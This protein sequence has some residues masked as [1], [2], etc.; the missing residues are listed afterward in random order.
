MQFPGSTHND[1]KF[2]QQAHTNHPHPPMSVWKNLF[3]LTP[4]EFQARIKK[5]TSVMRRQRISR[6]PLRGGNK[7]AS[8]GRHFGL[9]MAWQRVDESRSFSQANGSCAYATEIKYIPALSLGNPSDTGISKS[10]L[11]L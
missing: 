9:R 5:N 11:A 6:P 3:L 2:W 7:R 8:H 1:G 10:S 4:R